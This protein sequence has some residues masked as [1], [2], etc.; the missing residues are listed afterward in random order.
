MGTA[1][2]SYGPTGYLKVPAVAGI[3]TTVGGIKAMVTRITGY[4]QEERR[5][6]A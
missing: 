3:R 1:V 4:Y 2:P 5:P 6:E